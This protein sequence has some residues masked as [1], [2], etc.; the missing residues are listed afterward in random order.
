MCI[1]DVL[2]GIF[3][4]FF[5]FEYCLL[6]VFHSFAILLLFSNLRV[7][8]LNFLLEI[9]PGIEINFLNNFFFKS[10]FCLPMAWPIVWWSILLPAIQVIF[11]KIS[12]FFFFCVCMKTVRHMRKHSLRFPGWN[13]LFIFYNI[14]LKLQT[15]FSSFFQFYDEK[16]FFIDTVMLCTPSLLVDHVIMLAEPWY[17]LIRHV[18]SIQALV[19]FI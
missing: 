13:L 14:L 17:T 12:A 6:H 8:F 5:S 3:I 19:R 10:Y 9:P 2:L 7:N 1:V 16:R 4:P 15:N 11:F 18:W